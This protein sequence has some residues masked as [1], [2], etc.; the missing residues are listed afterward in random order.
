MDLI[1]DIYNT[2]KNSIQ[3]IISLTSLF[4]LIISIISIFL[5][6]KFK[7]D[8]NYAKRAYLTPAPDPGKF[9]YNQENK[10]NL[11]IKLINSGLNPLKEITGVLYL[12]NSELEM[13]GSIKELNSNNPI[14]HNDLFYIY[15]DTK[16]EKDEVIYQATSHLKLDI[17]YYDTLLK[18]YFYDKFYWTL[19]N[20]PK[21]YGI[22]RLMECDKE[23]Y[24]KLKTD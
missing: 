22:Y 10:Y 7:K 18:R 16:T 17:S 14:P 9:N 20:D 19:I 5:T 21:N 11:E 6:T 23:I 24:N 13:I 15:S 12:Y 2:I 1:G 8:D 4:A 3:I